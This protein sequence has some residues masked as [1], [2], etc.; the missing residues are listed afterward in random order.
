M[1]IQIPDGLVFDQEKFIKDYCK[2]E[3]PTSWAELDHGKWVSARVP[4]EFMDAYD[5]HSKLN[6][7]KQAYNADWVPDW[8]DDGPKYCIHFYAGKVDTVNSNLMSF[9]LAFPTEEKRD[10]FLKHHRELI[11]QAKELL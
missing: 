1:N 2:E 11:E 9:F 10:H 7:L 8:G 3:L 6:E 5:A 4:V